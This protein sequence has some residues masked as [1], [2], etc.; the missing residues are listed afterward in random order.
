MR[1][2]GMEVTEENLARVEAA[3]AEARAVMAGVRG[4]LRQHFDGIDLQQPLGPEDF[5]FT[6][7][8]G[9]RFD[10]EMLSGNSPRENREGTEP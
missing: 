5:A 6:L 4:T 2:L 8:P 9:T 3:L 1:E 10:P 7:P